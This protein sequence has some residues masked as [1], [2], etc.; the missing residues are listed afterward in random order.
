MEIDGCLVLV[1]RTIVEDD[2]PVCKVEGQGAMLE[3]RHQD[4]EVFI[5]T[6][7]QQARRRGRRGARCRIVGRPKG[8][9]YNENREGAGYGSFLCLL[10]SDS[11][12]PKERGEKLM[13]G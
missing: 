13:E 6:A 11:A 1:R 3:L 2:L 10:S 9:I 8:G 5:H 4:K 12:C 7:K